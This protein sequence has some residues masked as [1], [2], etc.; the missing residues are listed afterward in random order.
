GAAAST[1]GG[2]RSL[3]YRIRVQALDHTLKDAEIAAVR[4]R[5]IEAASN[6]HGATLR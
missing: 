4:E 6:G 5:L 1:G 3:A 2:G